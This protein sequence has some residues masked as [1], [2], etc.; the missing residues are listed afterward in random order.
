M[1]LPLDP[2]AADATPRLLT[3]GLHVN[4]TE[5]GFTV[6][7]VNFG[8]RAAKQ[9]IE[10]CFQIDAVEVLSRQPRQGMDVLAGIG[11]DRLG[12]AAPAKAPRR[13]GLRR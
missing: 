12:G 10:T 9:G 3:S 6:N 1:V 4:R 11:A 13:C 2:P 7:E 5:T 8:N